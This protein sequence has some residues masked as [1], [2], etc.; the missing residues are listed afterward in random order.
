MR[1]ERIGSRAQVGE[2]ALGHREWGVRATP[3]IVAGEGRKDKDE[4]GKD[5]QDRSLFL[6]SIRRG[7]MR[8]R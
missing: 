8:D 5:R 6:F 2:S 4:E 7:G 1:R 3:S